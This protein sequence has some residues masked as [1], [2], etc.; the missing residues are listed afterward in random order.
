MGGVTSTRAAP[1]RSGR[2][3]RGVVV[4]GVV[5]PPIGTVVA[6]DTPEVP[7]VVRVEPVL[8]PDVEVDARKPEPP[9]ECPQPTGITNARRR[10]VI[11]VA[12]ERKSHLRTRHG[13]REAT[14]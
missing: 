5:E 11:G 4:E 10:A 7:D 9:P 12:R 13:E 6:L 8:V 1:A 3:A 14:L 2:F